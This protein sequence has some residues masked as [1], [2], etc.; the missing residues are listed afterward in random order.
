MQIT[1]MPFIFK[2][3]MK[4]NYLIIIQVVTNLPIYL[5]S[6]TRCDTPRISVGVGRDSRI[7]I[8]YD[9]D[10]LFVPKHLVIYTR[11]L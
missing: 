10:L 5:S 1:A 4:E 8:S 9:P 11:T 7:K 3:Y 2:L 6:D